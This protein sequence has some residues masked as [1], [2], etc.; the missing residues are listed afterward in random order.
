MEWLERLNKS[1]NYIENNL[2][3]SIYIE[4]AAK[5]ACCSIYHYQRIFRILQEFL[6]QNI[7]AAEE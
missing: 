4:E 6:C 2:A 3:E 1:I 5:T 7:S